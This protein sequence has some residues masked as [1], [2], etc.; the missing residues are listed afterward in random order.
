MKAIYTLVIFC[1]FLSCR[2]TTTE[3]ELELTKRE[4]ELAKKELKSKK[5]GQGQSLGKSSSHECPSCAQT[6]R[7]KE[8]PFDYL[9]TS[10]VEFIPQSTH[11][12][13][14]LLRKETFTTKASV[15]Y[16]ISNNAKYVSYK[17]VSVQI[18]CL[19]KNGK[20]IAT[21]R[22]PILGILYPGYNQINQQPSIPNGTARVRIMPALA[23]AID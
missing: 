15:R 8:R 16:R 4:L 22:I 13:K 1:L 5:G 17:N 6:E 21:A 9:A 19:D 14:V 11:T 20:E 7:E 18:D 3:K 23:T 12:K 2:Q 10:V